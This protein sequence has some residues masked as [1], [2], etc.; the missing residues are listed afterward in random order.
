M[1]GLEGGRDIKWGVFESTDPEARCL[2]IYRSEDAA[3]GWAQGVLLR[4]HPDA[5]VKQ[6]SP[7]QKLG[8]IAK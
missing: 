7:W 3:I 2:G 4:D 6:V 1:I 8:E 5:I